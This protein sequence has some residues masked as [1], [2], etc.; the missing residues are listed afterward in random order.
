MPAYCNGQTGEVVNI[1]I[2][3]YVTASC[4][5]DEQR[6][7]KVRYET[8]MPTG[9]GLG[10]SGAMN[11]ALVAAT[12]WLLRSRSPVPVAGAA[13]GALLAAPLS[14]PAVLPMGPEQ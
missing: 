13:I 8:E 11:V 4:E 10:T 5:I 9:C 12:W 2:D 6:R 3:R 7:V 14:P 1:A